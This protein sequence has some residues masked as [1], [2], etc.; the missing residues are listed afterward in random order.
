MSAGR[1]AAAMVGLQ[2]SL[3][4]GGCTLPDDKALSMV[5]T[6]KYALY[7]CNQ[8]TTQARANVARE[9]ELQEAIAKASRGAGGELVVAVAYRSEY[10]EIK[11]EIEE[12]ERVAA[13]KNCRNP[14]RAA[15]DTAIR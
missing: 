3:L 13:Q 14:L 7:D 10:L 9:R 6:G 11:G 2:L 1:H 15:S 5:N 12:M 8:L 4:A